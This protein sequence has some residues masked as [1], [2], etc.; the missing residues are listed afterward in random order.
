MLG[1]ESPRVERVKEAR[2]A[3]IETLRVQ[4]VPQVEQRVVEVMAE[5]VEERAEKSA[6]GD[7]LPAL[8][9]EHPHGHEVAA[10]AVGRRVEA[11]ELPSAQRR[12]T[13]GDAHAYARDTEPGADVVADA[14]RERLHVALP[15][16]GEHR[17]Q[18]RHGTL[19]RRTGA[20]R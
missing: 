3:L 2:L 17:R 11:L 10:T 16:G 19:E 1:L 18:R 7:H 6:E 5:L 12:P 9:G 4:R 8:G 13:R 15:T 20:Q 14:L